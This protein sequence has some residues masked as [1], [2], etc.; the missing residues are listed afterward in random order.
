LVK[1]LSACW[2]HPFFKKV[3][4]QNSVLPRRRIRKRLLPVGPVCAKP[5]FAKFR[6]KPTSQNAA[7]S[8]LLQ[9]AFRFIVA[10]AMPG[11]V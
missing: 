3:F 5:A 7:C 6:F 4:A 8:D 10:G 9:T 2:L 1:A 11:P